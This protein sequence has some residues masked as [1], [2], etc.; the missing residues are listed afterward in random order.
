MGLMMAEL[1]T[2]LEQPDGAAFFE[3]V[4]AGNSLPVLRGKL[5]A[6]HPEDHPKELLLA[7]GSPDEADIRI[8]LSK[9]LAN[10]APLGTSVDFEGVI[11]TWDKKPFALVFEV[12]FDG[13]HGWPK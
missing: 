9:P 6:Q 8:I 1:R 5:I 7:V 11:R 2:S 12:P 4:L 3:D 13:I 10:P